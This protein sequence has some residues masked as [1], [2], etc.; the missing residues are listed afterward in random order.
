[1]LCAADRRFDGSDDIG[2]DEE[3]HIRESDVIVCFVRV[4]GEKCACLESMRR[5]FDLRG[6]RMVEMSDSDAGTGCDAAD[7]IGKALE[8]GNNV[9]VIMP[10]DRCGDLWLRL[11]GRLK[12][13]CREIPTAS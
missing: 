10:S 12:A 4:P 8:A 3:R 2:E 5:R 13:Y 1:M 7:M 9:T 11:C 6:K